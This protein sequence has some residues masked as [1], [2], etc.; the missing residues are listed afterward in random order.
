MCN[1]TRKNSS[2]LYSR[3]T[4]VATL[5][6]SILWF[7][8]SASMAVFAD[9]GSPDKEANHDDVEVIEVRGIRASMAENMLLKR[10]SSA[11]V[12]VITAE[13]IGKFPD[14]NVADSLQR[15]PGVVI[16]RSGG[17]GST[18]SIRGL[19]SDLTFTQL[20]GNFIASSPGEPSRSFDYG[21]LPSAMIQRV[22]V[23]KSPEAR[24]DA[25]GVGGT[26]LLHSRKPLEMAAGS[27]VLNLESTYA[28]VTDKHEP[29]F[30]GVY[31]WK[32]EAESFGVLVGFTRQHRTNRTLSGGTNSNIWRWNGEEDAIDVDGNPVDND[33]GWGAVNDAF[34]NRYQGYWFPQVARTAVTN[35]SRERDGFQLSS[36]WRPTERTEFGFN[37]FGFRLGQD[38]TLSVVD[39]PEWSLNPNFLTNVTVDDSGTII[40]GMDYTVGAGGVQND[41]Q[42]PWMRGTYVREKS[43]SDTFDF[44]YNYYGDRFTLRFVA[45]NTKAKGGPTESW[46]AAYKS[47]NWGEGEDSIVNAAQYAGWSLGDRVSMY[48]DPNTLTNMLNGMGGGR[49]PGSSSSSFVRSTL[50]ERYAQVDLDV[51]VDWG[52]F[53]TVRTGLKLRDA[54]LHRETGNNFFLDPDFDIEGALA[55]GRGIDVF[56]SYQWNDGMPLAKDVFKTQGEGNIAG[57]FNINLMPVIDWDKYRDIILANYQLYTR[58]EDN[59]VYDIEEKTT[60]A[61]LQGDFEFSAFR[62]N[63]GLR[64]VRTKTV[65]SSTDLYTYFL[66]HT[67]DETGEPVTGDDRFIEQWDLITQVNTDTYA[68]PSLNLVWDASD[69]LV[70]RGA[71]ARVMSRPGYNSMGSQERITFISDEWAKDRAEFNELP[72]FRGSGGNKN[73]KPF[74]STQADLSIEYYYDTGSALGMA[75]FY[76]DVDNFVVPLIIDST[77]D[78][79]GMPGIVEEGQITISPYSTV[80]NGSNAKS[81][82]VELFMQHSF[83]SG[84]GVYANYTYNSTN[85]A[86]V[87]VEGEKF[88]ESP[89]VGSAKYQYNLSAYY[90]TDDYSVRASYNKRGQTV[91]GINSG[92]NVYQD[93]YAQIDVNGSYSLSENFILNASVINLTRSESTSR[94]GSDTQARLLNTSYSGRRF[95]AGFTYNF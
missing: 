47:S 18:V 6:S 8:A 14:K 1:K 36:Q 50:Q 83:D 61:Y 43:T 19:S 52:I 40:T 48:M 10:Y 12:D 66:D 51:D 16:Q 33:N 76:K 54:E 80:G 31:S 22:E 35:E 68:L 3:K 9:T 2:K 62:G 30:T 78:F 94:L 79:A 71:L 59:F 56:D 82:G 90:E 70:V 49:D 41:M 26:V 4:R 81:R 21:L 63:M 34:G 60:A 93:P 24:L 65:G 74:L 86:D 58:I 27:G 46:E 85:K 37:Y 25:G 55:S 75:L 95:Y 28:D 72:G 32:N 42:F 73:L 53:H 38:R 84:F 88:G 5:V 67:D 7:S 91:L 64:L 29:Q 89:L 39:I 69:D 44:N 45:G 57:G 77:R 20:N 87:N 11:V 15:V 92:L 23:F 17:E 13:D